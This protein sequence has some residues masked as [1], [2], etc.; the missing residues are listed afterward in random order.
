MNVSGEMTAVRPPANLTESWIVSDTEATASSNLI[1]Y[2]KSGSTI[3]N[4]IRGNGGICEAM[5]V[6]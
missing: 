3:V 4:T 6:A 1:P 5:V 2:M